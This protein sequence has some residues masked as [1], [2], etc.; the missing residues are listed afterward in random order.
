MDKRTMAPHSQNE[1][2]TRREIANGRK[3]RR[4]DRL[5]LRTDGR[6]NRQTDGRK[7]EL[8]SERMDRQT[9]EQTDGW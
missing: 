8:T 4:T 6:T 9:D 7:D 1:Q 2:A 5:N 3:D